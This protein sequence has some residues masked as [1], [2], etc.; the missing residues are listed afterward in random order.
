M[1]ATRAFARDKARACLSSAQLIKLQTQWI[2]F[3]QHSLD[4]LDDSREERIA[5]ASKQLHRNISSFK[6]LSAHEAS[7]LIDSLSR[8]LGIRD[9]DR[10]R[11]MGTDGRHGSSGR[12]VLTMVSTDDMRRI[13]DAV[14]RLGWDEEHL[15]NWLSS[16]SSPLRNGGRIQ[17][18]ADANRVWWA[19]K[20]ILKRKTTRVEACA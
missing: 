13:H 2:Q 16:S 9:R 7:L 18:L 14:A 19:L 3:A 17:T 6:D 12:R 8:C 11:A 15:T 5:W 1:N 10:A 4:V 20:S